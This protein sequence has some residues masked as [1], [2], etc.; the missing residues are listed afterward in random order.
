MAKF[1]VL[2]QHQPK[3]TNPNAI[4]LEK[5]IE[6]LI[7]DGYEGRADV[8]IKRYKDRY[9][10]P[11]FLERVDRAAHQILSFNFSE[12]TRK[13]FGLG[14]DGVHSINKTNPWWGVDTL[15]SDNSWKDYN[16]QKPNSDNSKR[17]DRED[18]KDYG[19]RAHEPEMNDG[20]EY[21]DKQQVDFGDKRLYDDWVGRPN[22]FKYTDTKEYPDDQLTTDLKLH[23]QEDDD[24]AMKKL[25]S[26]IEGDYRMSSIIKEV[27]KESSYM[28]DSFFHPKDDLLRGVTFEELIDTV[29]S[30]EKT[31]TPDVVKRVYRE[32]L[33]SNTHDAEVEL[34]DNM[35]KILKACERD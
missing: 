22:T 27:L 6:Q 19:D 2:R 31:I 3:N 20:L 29:Y 32:I 1:K 26:K 13:D 11:D 14:Y 30:N 23:H 25:R 17:R 34:K 7:E 15:Q 21:K 18:V 4:R 10:Q 16:R 28:K 12:L 24:E 33:R 5:E 9:G 8:L 35:E